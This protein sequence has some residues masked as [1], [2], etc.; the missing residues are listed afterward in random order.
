VQLQGL[1]PGAFKRDGATMHSTCTAPC[2]APHRRR[3]CE[4]SNASLLP[5]TVAG[6]PPIMRLAPPFAA[7]RDA[8]PSGHVPA[9]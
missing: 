5:Y 1:K 7:L 3:F 8:V 4:H 9:L 6:C 2:A